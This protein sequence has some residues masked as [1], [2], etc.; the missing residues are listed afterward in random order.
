MLDL[1]KVL[2]N[3]SKK[4]QKDDL[5]LEECRMS[6][7]ATKN[8][9]EV[10]KTNAGKEENEF[11]STLTEDSEYKTVKLLG[12]RDD[13]YDIKKIR[14]TICDNIIYSMNARYRDIFENKIL[15]N[16][17]I[18]DPLNLPKNEEEL[19]N[20]GTSEL[21]E[22]I[23]A[24]PASVSHHL[25]HRDLL[26]EYMFWKVW[27]KN[28]K[29]SISAVWNRF[30]CEQD[31]NE[32]DDCAGLVSIILMYKTLPISTAICERGFSLLNNIKTD[33]R[34][35]LNVDTLDILIRI[36]LHGPV[37]EDFDSTE[38]IEMWW[39]EAIRKRKPD[40]SRSKND[41][42]GKAGTS[43]SAPNKKLK[44]VVEVIDSSD[45]D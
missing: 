40:F 18:F 26:A 39:Q 35:K 41:N 27:A 1:T 17:H 34:N 37:I 3:L 22:I 13:N 7:E 45:S 43:G 2:S 29:G 33:K 28:K 10:L 24:L 36:K 9:V 25:E 21:L 8:L 31:T 15:K 5:S 20:F 23:E 4:L 11:E 12:K 16:F 38:A 14:S 6:I 44:S 42:E 32:Q 19:L 30:I